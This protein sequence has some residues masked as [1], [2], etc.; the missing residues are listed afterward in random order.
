MPFCDLKAIVEFLYRGEVVVPVEQVSSLSKSAQTLFI[1]GLEK[2][3]NKS[4]VVDVSNPSTNSSDKTNNNLRATQPLQPIPLSAH[5]SKPKQSL[6]DSKRSIGMSLRKTRRPDYRQLS[7]GDFISEEEVSDN[8]DNHSNE[9]KKRFSGHSGHV[10]HISRKIKSEMIYSE[11]KTKT[12]SDSFKVIEKSD[13]EEEDY[14]EIEMESQYDLQFIQ[15]DNDDDDDDTHNNQMPST[16]RGKPSICRLPPLT[17]RSPQMKSA[18]QSRN[19]RYVSII[20]EF[21]LICF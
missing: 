1:K 2:Y 10:S 18:V 19:Q 14:S 16:S 4:A 13:N 9:R 12:N 11:E 17:K 7:N 15:Q 3:F 6:N 8:D 5:K 21:V 20:F